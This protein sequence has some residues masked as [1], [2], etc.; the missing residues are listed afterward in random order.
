MK[1]FTLFTIIVTSLLSIQMFSQANDKSELRPDNLLQERIIPHSI[2]DEQS[3][4]LTQS[5]FFEEGESRTLV[6]KSILDNGFLLTEELWQE[7][8]GSNWVNYSKDTY[9]YDGNNN[10]IEWLWQNW[11]GSYW[12]N[13]RKYTYTYDGN[14]NMI[15]RLGQN[16]DSSYWVNREKYTF[17]YDG[18]NNMIEL[19][20]QT[21]DGSNWV[22]DRKNTLTYDGNNNMIEE[23]WQNWDGSNWVNDYKFTYTYDV[24][25]NMIEWLWQD[26]DGS[27]WVYTDKNTYTYDGNNNM[28]EELWQGW[29]GSN[30]VNYSKH[31][32]TYDVNNNMIE[33]LWQNWFGSWVNFWKWTYTYD[34]NNNMIEELRQDWDGSNWVNDKKKIYT[35]TITGIEQLADGIKTY[36]L[37]NNYPNPFNPSTTISYSVPEIEFVTIKVYYVLGNEVAILVNEEKSVGSYE[38]EFNATSLPSG[39]YFYRIQA[40]TFIETKKMVLL[41]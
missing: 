6:N 12:V 15:E 11:D 32:Y 7:W 31:T 23:L 29:D 3:R 37:S 28:I 39:I 40:G 27:N 19:L 4:H 14:N 36:S 5:D 2:P 17:T 20:R 21:W 22:N 38:V 35:Y 30:W 34:G 41:R 18:N 16:W 25:N 33:W 10:M 9:T 8:D 26:W 1:T 24:N 13:N